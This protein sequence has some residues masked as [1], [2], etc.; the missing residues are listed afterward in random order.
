MVELQFS[1]F[2]DGTV[3]WD[4]KDAG[5]HP[6]ASGVYLALVRNSAG[7]KIVKFAIER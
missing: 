3:I 2:N 5:G 4:G 6:V 1:T 7:N